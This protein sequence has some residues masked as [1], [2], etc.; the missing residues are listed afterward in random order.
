M[1][2]TNFRDLLSTAR[3]GEE[4]FIL[5]Q[6]FPWPPLMVFALYMIVVRFGP[7]LMAK[8]KSFELRR[9]MIVYNFVQVVLN[10]FI[11]FKVSTRL[12]MHDAV[13]LKFT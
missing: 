5:I 6:C 13:V 4:H 12:C 10:L 1:W 8:R 7:E 9:V 11:A 2:I 3:D